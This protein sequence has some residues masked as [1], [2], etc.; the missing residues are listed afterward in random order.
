MHET[1]GPYA[2]GDDSNVYAES[3]QCHL[4][5]ASDGW[6]CLKDFIGCGY[7]IF[8]IRWTVVEGH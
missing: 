5:Y 2:A 8:K 7:H 4:W 6:L 3:T 1:D